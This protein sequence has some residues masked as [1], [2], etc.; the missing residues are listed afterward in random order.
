MSITVFGII[1]CALGLFLQG[2]A[3]L[4]LLVICTLFGATGAAFLGS[5]TITPAV[6]AAPFFLWLVYAA[7]T[8]AQSQSFTLNSKSPILWSIAFSTYAIITA[9]TLPTVFNDGSILAFM[10]DRGQG[11]TATAILEPVRPVSTNITQSL[12]LLSNTIIYCGAIYL[13]RFWNRP[14]ILTNA[15][16]L[17]AIIN[18]ILAIINS[19]QQFG[20]PDILVFLKNGNYT[21]HGGSVGGLIRISGGF[22]ETSGWS[23]YSL[24]LLG[25]TQALWIKG[26]RTKISAP[27]T[28]ATLFFLLISTSGTAYGGLAVLFLVIYT[29][30]AYRYF[31]NQKN[32]NDSV[33]IYALLAFFILAITLILFKP[34]TLNIISNFIDTAISGKAESE[35]GRTRSSW[36]HHAWLNFIDTYG[37]GTGLGTNISSGFIT[38]L[39]SNT[40]WFGTLLFGLFIFRSLS[41]EDGNNDKNHQALISAGK[42]GMI[43]IL[44]AAAFSARVF[45]LGM[46]FYLFAA[47]T[48]FQT[49]ARQQKI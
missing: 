32:E 6:M 49:S 44:S 1:V 46:T 16:L 10:N 29:T 17:T 13:I 3:R 14:T 43:G 39:P 7:S 47:A 5:A 25:F 27:I 26:Y 28:L 8:S 37:F 21:I 20:F 4:Y 36:N 23:A 18:I 42:W 48:A 41:Q 2:P 35:S 19:L 34:D 24:G 33:Y 9:L 12:Y 15:F 45:D 22:P 30:V 40:G 11:G 38:L 31:T